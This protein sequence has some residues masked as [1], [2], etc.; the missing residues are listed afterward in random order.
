M[1]MSFIAA[2]DYE[3]YF[4]DSAEGGEREAA[5]NSSSSS[6][7]DSRLEAV[8][9][10]S[11][12]TNS[13]LTE[14]NSSSNSEGGGGGGGMVNQ[15]GEPDD[16][17]GGKETLPMSVSAGER[18]RLKCRPQ[19]IG[20]VNRPTDF[21]T[22]WYHNDLPIAINRQPRIKVLDSRCVCTVCL[23]RSW[24]RLGYVLYTGHFI[25]LLLV[26]RRCFLI[27]L[28]FVYMLQKSK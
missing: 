20:G 9:T 8:N 3:Y 13:R 25:L 27:Y 22:T 17:V 4:S 10:S 6:I 12:D 11:N 2:D 7:T 1:V 24:L 21:K 5:P 15:D 26:F 23:Y 19:Q 18:V 14:N 28:C 16:G